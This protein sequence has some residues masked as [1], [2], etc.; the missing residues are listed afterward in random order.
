[1]LTFAFLLARARGDIIYCFSDTIENRVAPSASKKSRTCVRL[2]LERNLRVCDG[3]CLNKLPPASAINTAVCM[4]RLINLVFY[5][6]VSSFFTRGCGPD[7]TLV[8]A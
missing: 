2:G 5:S 8:S 3:C 7:K 6:E 4:L 1:M